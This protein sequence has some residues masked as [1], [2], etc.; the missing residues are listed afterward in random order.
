MY[1]YS[2]NNVTTSAHK[3]AIQKGGK[4]EKKRFSYELKYCG[5][6]F[7]ITFKLMTLSQCNAHTFME[8]WKTNKSRLGSASRG[9][10]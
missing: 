1:S 5:L 9:V 8:K 6:G 3:M 4:K 7:Q 10:P 2:V